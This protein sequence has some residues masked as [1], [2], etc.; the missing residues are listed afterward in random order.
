MCDLCD[1]TSASV[2]EPSSSGFTRKAL[3]FL[4]FC[5]KCFFLLYVNHFY[6]IFIKRYKWLKFK[7]KM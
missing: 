2:W 7:V 1:A 4:A 3:I 5:P 6:V